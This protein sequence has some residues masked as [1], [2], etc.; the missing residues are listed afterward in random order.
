VSEASTRRTVLAGAG[1]GVLAL[2]ALTPAALAQRERSD[3]EI[4]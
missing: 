1:T 2:A 4:I 3:V